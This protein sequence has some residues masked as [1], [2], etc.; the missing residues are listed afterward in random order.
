MRLFKPKP[1]CPKCDC[2]MVKKGGHLECICGFCCRLKA[3][4]CYA[5]GV[6]LDEEH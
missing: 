6:I 3:L 1:R 2:L 4:R 5:C